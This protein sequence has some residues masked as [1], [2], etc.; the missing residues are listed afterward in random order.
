MD[1]ISDM[2]IRLKNAQAVK[3]ESVEV[4]HSKLKA[5]ILSVLEKNGY[6]GEV[7]KKGKKVKKFLAVTL[8]YGQDGV[9][10]IGGL[11]RVSKL[12]RR[13]YKKFSE[14]RPVR[15]GKGILVVSTSKGLKT[16]L[17]AKKEKI[18]GE[19]LFKIW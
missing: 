8:L 7:Q 17:E 15:Q 12:S 1:P 2:L 11:E 10:R 6:V 16:D 4:P 14:L 18:G 9:G 13:V 5:E 3:H 19:V